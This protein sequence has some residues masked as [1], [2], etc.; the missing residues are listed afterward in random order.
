MCSQAFPLNTVAN[1]L[2]KMLMSLSVW[3]KFQINFLSDGRR[4]KPEGD[5]CVIS[6]ATHLDKHN[7]S[8]RSSKLQSN[9]M[10]PRS[11]LL[12]PPKGQQM[13][14]KCRTNAVQMH[15]VLLLR[16]T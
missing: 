12:L 3:E 16:S 7:N 5:G 8:A 9:K 13:R 15:A 11:G 6:S 1:W 2:N 4:G 14:G 10:S